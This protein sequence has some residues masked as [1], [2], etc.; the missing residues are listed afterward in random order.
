[1]VRPELVRVPA[2]SW[3]WRYRLR[4]YL[5]GSLWLVPLLGIVVGYVLAITVAWAQSRI[6]PGRGW[7]YPA[8]AASAVLTAIIG[9][10]VALFGFVVMISV[11][12]VQMA[13]GTLSP[14]F[15]RL[16]YRDRLQKL[17]LAFF[18]G[19][20]S[21]SFRLLRETNEEVPSLGV[22]LAGISFGTSLI[23]LLL[24]LDRFAHNLRPVGVGAMVA[25]QGLREAHRS[26][27]TATAWRVRRATDPIPAGQ[28]SAVI[29]FDGEGGAIQ[30]IHLRSLVTEAIRTDSVVVLD[31]TVG[32]FITAG[33]PLVNVYAHGAAPSSRSLVSAIATGSE[34][35]IE[36]DPAFAMR[37]L[38]D[39]AIRALS[40]AVND[41]TTGVQ[42]TNQI[43]MLLRG[44]LPYLADG[45]YL[46]IADH[47]DVPRLILR[48]RTFEDYLQLAVTEIREYGATSTQICRRLL[49][50]LTE[51][52]ERCG[53]ENAA[54]VAA[55]LANL[56]RTIAGHA[57]DPVDLAVAHTPDR[58]GLGAP[59]DAD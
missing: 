48:A 29:A 51:L 19:T 9:A 43:E 6:D 3:A 56:E 14:R 32:D 16:W 52:A 18:V 38:V 47:A 53:P 33:T 49:A 2:F 41:P 40:P 50:M 34:R 4:Q 44:L 22:T 58:Q 7:T 59:R 24:Y 10:M 5:K 1:M 15:M 28:P 8:G 23:L 31:C 45:R 55:E 30:A 17:V 35:S 57:Q 12:V 36:D 21:F 42:L 11:L 39:I 20:V 27:R 25:R 26:V 54:V 46:V 37:I 13:T